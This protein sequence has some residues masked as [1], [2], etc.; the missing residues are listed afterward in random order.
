MTT[1]FSTKAAKFWIAA[2][3]AVVIAGLNAY[4]VAFSDGVMS[5]QEWVTIAA[6]VIGAITVYL[7]P[8]ATP[9]D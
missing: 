2:I 1:L 5:T 8:N 6:A 3:A 7:V 4:E 9:E